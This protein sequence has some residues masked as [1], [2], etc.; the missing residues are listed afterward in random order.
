VAL[1]DFQQLP[2]VVVS[3]GTSARRWLSRDLFRETGVVGEEPGALPAPGDRLCALLSEQYRMRPEIRA[4]VSELFYGGRLRDAAERAES[5]PHATLAVVDTT[6]L[7]PRVER[8]DGSRRNAVHLEVALQLLEV[9]ARA[10][11]SD[12]AV[13]TPYRV[14]TRSLARRAR[15]RLGPIAPAALEVAT[16]HRFQGREKNVVILDTVDAPPDRSWFLDETRNRDFPRLL[17][18]AL[19]RARELLVV[20]GT[21]EGLRRTL[22]RD[23]LLNRALERMLRDGIRVDGRRPQDLVTDIRAGSGG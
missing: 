14:Q 2:A 3:R 8:E 23:A 5:V 13:V 10:G 7:D 1:G 12:V 16:I 19:S 22:P 9:L 21:V 20:L 18:V 6:G 11:A 15:A 4:L 17:N